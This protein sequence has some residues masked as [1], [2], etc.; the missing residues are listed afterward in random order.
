MLRFFVDPVAVDVQLPENVVQIKTSRP[1]LTSTTRTCICRTCM[2]LV[3]VCVLG[4]RVLM[5]GSALA[6]GLRWH[7]VQSHLGEGLA[8]DSMDIH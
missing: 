5:C 2:P 7:A 6:V 1:V 3:A 8:N 4:L